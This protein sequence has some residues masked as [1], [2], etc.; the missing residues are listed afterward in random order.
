MLH[1][2]VSFFR[3]GYRRLFLETTLILIHEVVAA[4]GLAL[5]VL[6]ADHRSLLGMRLTVLFGLLG[7]KV[8]HLKG[9]DHVLLWFLDLLTDLLQLGLLNVRVLFLVEEVA[10]LGS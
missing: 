10:A 2:A 7:L 6:G 4:L 1:I 3:V 9:L 5:V 8:T